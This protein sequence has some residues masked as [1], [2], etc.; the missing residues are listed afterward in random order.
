[1][2][3]KF[4]KFISVFLG[5][6]FTFSAFGCKEEVVTVD[7]KAGTDVRYYEG[8]HVFTAPDTDKKLVENG[9]TE[10]VLVTP[11]NPTS[12]ETTARNEF[13]SLF[14][15]ATNIR[16]REQKDSGLTYDENSKYI[17]IGDTTLLSSSG[18]TIDKD[19]LTT[20]GC[21]II[22][23][24]NTIFISGGEEEGVIY[25]V[26]DFMEIMFN[27]DVFYKDCITIDTNVKDAPLKN[28]DVTDIPDFINRPAIYG[29]LSEQGTTE[30][31][32]M[33]KTRMRINYER[34]HH[35]GIYKEFN[36][37][38]GSAS[39]SHCTTSHILTREMYEEE[40]PGWFSD[41]GDQWCYTAHGNEEE[42]D[43]MIEEIVKK[44]FNTLQYSLPGTTEN[45]SFFLAQSD[46]GEN[47]SCQACVDST[48]K[49]GAISGAMII[50]IN[51]VSRL[52]RE[53]YLERQAAEPDN[54]M[55][56]RDVDYFYFQM[57]GYLFSVLPPTK[58]NEVTQKMEATYPEVVC[59]DNV[60]V[61]LALTN[62]WTWHS[63]LSEENEQARSTI[64]GW[65]AICKNV[66]Y[67]VYNGN[68]SAGCMYPSVDFNFVNGETYSWL[69]AQNNYS[70]YTETSTQR[71]TLTAWTALTMYVNYKLQ[72]NTSLDVRELQ[73][74]W[75]KAMFKDAK[76]IEIMQGLYEEVDQYRRYVYIEDGGEK[77]F[78]G[79]HVEFAKYFPYQT[80]LTWYEKCNDALAS[81]EK[82]K[83]TAV[84]DEVFYH[85]ESE[86]ISIMYLMLQHYN[87]S[88]SYNFRKEIKDRLATDIIEMNLATAVVDTGATLSSW[89]DK[90]P[91]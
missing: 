41:N 74:K 18:L 50:L 78:M 52:F 40:H 38:N 76:T 64:A 4:I 49:Y 36:Q 70:L 35:L 25:S 10:Y 51:R 1:M 62:A 56:A 9:A 63:I 11:E 84:Y 27:Y 39:S 17:S 29:V 73:N 77:N 57:F 53:Q 61:L 89:L 43:L 2:K 83:G 15:K 34:N 22:T 91:D 6:L 68:F 46:N 19:A 82:Y 5:S 33:F 3:K 81:I 54:P 45:Y 60:I 71:G 67:W 30:D 66:E 72:W 58:L 32:R 90:I 14:R 48:A 16:I 8:T 79:K 65:G 88:M 42:L 23:K 26:Y 47:C 87:K 44:C 59:D 86:A 7:E 69:A 31:S 80:V 20:G 13:V 85:I 37:P 55:Y 24:G 75:F 12:Y 28:F 21:R